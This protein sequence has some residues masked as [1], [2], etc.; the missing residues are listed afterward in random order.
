MNW[1]N[2]KVFKFLILIFSMKKIL[3]LSLV[4]V[5]L[6]SSFVFAED[7]CID[8]DDESELYIKGTVESAIDDVVN[9]QTDYCIDENNLREYFC[10]SG[11]TMVG[12]IA[13]TDKLCDRG[14]EDGACISIS[15]AK[16]AQREST[17]CYQH[18][19]EC[20]MEISEGMTETSFG[21]EAT[22]GTCYLY[23]LSEGASVD[24]EVYEQG[25][26][27]KTY[28][29]S[30]IFG[31]CS[32]YLI[33]PS[34]N[35]IDTGSGGCNRG[36]GSTG[37]FSADSRMEGNYGTW[38]YGVTVTDSEGKSESYETTFE[39][40]FINKIQS[41]CVVGWKED[42]Y[43][44]E[45]LGTVYTVVVEEG[46]KCGSRLEAT[47]KYDDK[48][49]GISAIVGERAVLE[50]GVNIMP[51][52]VPCSVDIINLEFSEYVEAVCGD[53]ICEIGD[54]E[55]DCLIETIT[56]IDVTETENITADESTTTETES[57][58]TCDN[59][60]YFDG[61]C[62]SYGLRIASSTENLF[63]DIEGGFV[64]QK[65]DGETCQN[66][67]ECGTNFCSNGVCYDIAGEVAETKGILESIMDFLRDLFGFSSDV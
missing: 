63:C 43:I 15:A 21:C 46:S 59:G 13:H 33:S 50:N 40:R 55:E 4:L 57:V 35:R 36:Q 29:N 11:G 60:C 31:D 58:T 2:C 56:I 8:T 6:F 42:S 3:I 12:T 52:G 54:C 17:E 37:E 45:F 28:V 27:I 34:G 10:V 32:E 51:T 53:G 22:G 25:D 48:E 18:R 1:R 16:T 7:Y 47:I 19:G 49:K 20:Q 38:T 26:Y 9:T 24:K 62:L 61:K 5:V 44:C 41:R 23:D 64:S 67:Y 30:P 65:L 66:N 39:Y 14:C